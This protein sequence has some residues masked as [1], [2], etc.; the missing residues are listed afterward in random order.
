M[1]K[2]EKENHSLRSQMLVKD[3]R[4][5]VVQW[6]NQTQGGCP[7]PFYHWLNTC[8]MKYPVKDLLSVVYD[9]DLVTGMVNLFK[10]FDGGVIPIRT[11]DKRP[12][13]FYIYDSP[14]EQG[15]SNQWIQMTP[16]QLN[17]VFFKIENLFRE[18]Y[19]SHWFIPNAV[20]MATDESIVEKH[21]TQ[22]NKIFG[23]KEETVV[24]RRHLTK[25]LYGLLKVKM[26]SE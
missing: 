9:T 12:N 20:L 6:L 10:Q 19:M 7:D 1:D 8:L 15:S 18:T 2:L 17:D 11:V 3:K 22:Y 26:E 21:M 5:D 13:I 14:M 4:V 23:G 25:Q 16:E 24:R